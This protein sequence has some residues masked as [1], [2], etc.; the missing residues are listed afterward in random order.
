MFRLNY[1]KLAE[2]STGDPSV[3]SR[4]WLAFVKAETPIYL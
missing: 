4:I 1:G 3:G 2:N